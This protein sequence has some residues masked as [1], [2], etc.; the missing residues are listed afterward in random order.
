VTSPRNPGETKSKKINKA[1]KDI[2]LPEFNTPDNFVDLCDIVE[3]HT[4]QDL[5]WAEELAKVADTMPGQ[6]KIFMEHAIRDQTVLQQL[7]TSLVKYRAHAVEIG[8]IYVAM[9][10]QHRFPWAQTCEEKFISW[11]KY[12]ESHPFK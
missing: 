2:G 5:L 6:V 3:S 4:K 12:E 7:N 8:G 9:M 11:S 10:E 1:M